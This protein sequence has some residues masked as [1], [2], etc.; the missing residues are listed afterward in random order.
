[1]GFFSCIAAKL[2]AFFMSLF[3]GIGSVAGFAP[4]ELEYETAY[5]NPMKGFM[6]F[7][8]QGGESGDNLG[9][10][11]EWFY[12]PMSAIVNK[13]GEF[14]IKDAIE[15]YLTDIASRGNQGVFRVYLDYPGEEK[16]AAGEYIRNMGVKFYGY[17]QYGGGQTPDYSDDRL[18]DFLC[19]FIYALADEYDGDGRIAY[20]TA[21]LIGHWG[22][23]HVCVD[24]ANPTDEQKARIIN[25]YTD[26]FKTTKILA[27]YP[28]D[29]GTGDGGVGFHDD[30]FTYETI[31]NS[32]SW[33]FYTRLKKNKLT[34]IW[35]TQPV[36]GEFRP[37]CQEPFLTGGE[38]DGMQDY[39]ECV[40]K[41]HCSWLMAQNAFTLPLTDEQRQKA[42]DA[43]A[44]LGYDFYIDKANVK[45]SFGKVYAY[46]RVRNDGAAPIYA[47]P[48]V[49]I[50]TDSGEIKAENISLCDIMPGSY[51]V[52]KV[53]IGEECSGDVYIRAGSFFDGGKCV[54]FSNKGAGDRFIIGHI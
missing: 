4:T 10:S 31:D 25:A 14:K 13:N 52:F 37:E 5:V 39:G 24:E 2:T 41:T 19:K 18:T 48:G 33:F 7:Y 35:K 28:G 16:D 11:M 47:D 26:A 12:I 51:G 36:G 22:E 32:K 50:G 9:Y 42:K 15:P 6:P 8:T 1:M 49:F 45:K 30:S 20:I 23:W 17:T 21:G 46:V 54:R 43:S 44:E 29:P 38:Y 3:M 27:R 40:D 53:E 34:K